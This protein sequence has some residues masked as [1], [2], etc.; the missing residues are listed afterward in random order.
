MF[1]S[2]LLLK[3][4]QFRYFSFFKISLHTIF[5]SLTK[6]KTLFLR[7]LKCNPMI[8]AIFFC[9]FF[10]ALCRRKELVECRQSLLEEMP[11]EQSYEQIILLNIYSIKYYPCLMYIKRKQGLMFQRR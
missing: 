10:S 1:V 9:L 5:S 7:L 3:C 2:L 11:I 8:P 4:L 6:A